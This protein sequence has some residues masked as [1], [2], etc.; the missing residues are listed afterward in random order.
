MRSADDTIL[1]PIR[2]ADLDIDNMTLE[3]LEEFVAKCRG[4]F[5]KPAKVPKEKKPK[6]EKSQDEV[7]V[8]SIDDIEGD[9]G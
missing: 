1:N 7:T 3:E 8:I 2:I 5:Y 4:L 9:L 6:K